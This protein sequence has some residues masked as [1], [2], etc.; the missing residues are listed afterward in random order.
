MFHLTPDLTNGNTY[1]IGKP[2]SRGL[3]LTYPTI[4]S[5][6]NVDPVFTTK[7]PPAREPW[8]LIVP[9]EVKTAKP[10]RVAP[11]TVDAG[12]AAELLIPDGT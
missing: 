1:Y 3:S 8:R 11:T 10:I 2:P 12:K 4:L 5:T 9:V 7:F 6:I